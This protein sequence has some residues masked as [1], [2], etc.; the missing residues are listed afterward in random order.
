MC[1]YVYGS[2]SWLLFITIKL[3]RCTVILF[4]SFHLYAFDLSIEI[5]IHIFRLHDLQSAIKMENSG[6]NE[7]YTVSEWASEWERE[8]E[9][10]W[11]W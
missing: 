1:V 3:E 8:K 6:R 4:F 5:Q 2:D 11:M 10:D 7:E 9:A